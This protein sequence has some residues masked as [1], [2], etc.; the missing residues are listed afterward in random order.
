[1]DRVLNILIIDD[2]LI[3]RNN[4]VRSFE[5]LGHGVIAQAQD[6]QEGIDAYKKFKPDFVTMDITMPQ[7][8]GITALKK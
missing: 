6:G 3:M 2:S 5:S 8:D 7:M 4:L 1:M